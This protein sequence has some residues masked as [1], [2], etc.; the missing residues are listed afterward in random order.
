MLYSFGRTFEYTDISDGM[1]IP[2]VCKLRICDGQLTRE[3]YT[4]RVTR[5]ETVTR[6][7][8]DKF[9]F[10]AELSFANYDIIEIDEGTG[11]NIYNISD[12]QMVLIGP[13]NNPEII[14]EVWSLLTILRQD[15]IY[16]LERKLEEKEV[17]NYELKSKLNQY[18]AK[19]PDNI[20][21]DCEKERAK[22]KKDFR[23]LQ[24]YLTILN[25]RLPE[26]DDNIADAYGLA[27]SLNEQLQEGDN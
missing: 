5:E 13:S 2:S 24:N 17:E 10:T 7:E 4:L 15:Y 3:Y 11:A 12:D 16:D 20:N 23:D 25:K 21:N 6:G 18:S 22:F 19:V 26:I 27:C 1:N 9:H 8:E 14:N